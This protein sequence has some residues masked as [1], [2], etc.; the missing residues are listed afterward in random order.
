MLKQMKTFGMRSNESNKTLKCQI[1]L[2]RIMSE[3]TTKLSSHSLHIRIQEIVDDI[4]ILVKS[5]KNKIWRPDSPV[6][7]SW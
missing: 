6:K 2:K 1:L 4:T 3:N 7:C 5:H